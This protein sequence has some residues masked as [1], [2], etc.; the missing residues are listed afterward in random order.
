MK[1]NEETASTKTNYNILQ[2]DP[3]LEEFPS[4]ENLALSPSPSPGSSPQ[5]TVRFIFIKT[6]V[7]LE[8]Q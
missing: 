8:W 2:A 4:L 6:K 3:T 1:E 5:F 7:S